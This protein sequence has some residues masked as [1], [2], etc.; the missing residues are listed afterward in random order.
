MAAEVGLTLVALFAMPTFSL[1]M[2]LQELGIVMKCYV[3]EA[4]RLQLP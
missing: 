1:S 4:F 3:W 2:F